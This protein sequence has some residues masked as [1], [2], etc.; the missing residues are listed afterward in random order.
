MLIAQDSLLYINEKMSANNLFLFLFLEKSELVFA[1][2][3]IT[4]HNKTPYF[5]YLL[6]YFKRFE[7][8]N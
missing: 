6:T 3:N 2:L 5:Y 1:F 7:Y 8:P 4:S